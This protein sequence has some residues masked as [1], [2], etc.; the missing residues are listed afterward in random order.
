[1]DIDIDY[2]GIEQSERWNIFHNQWETPNKK[3]ENIDVLSKLIPNFFDFDIIIMDKFFSTLSDPDGRE[4]WINI[5]RSYI[6][7][8]MKSDAFL[9]F[10]DV[11]DQSRGRDLFDKRISPLFNSHEHYKTGGYGFEYIEIENKEN[12]FTVYPE[13]LNV[14][15]KS[16]LIKEVFFVYEN[17]KKGRCSS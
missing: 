3:I 7:K 16:D 11:N 10:K 13:N 1:M 15:P 2:I 8:Q 14:Y 17:K 12:V 4:K 5:L 9:I 6:Q